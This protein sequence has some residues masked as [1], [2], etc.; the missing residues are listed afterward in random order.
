MHFGCKDGARAKREENCFF[1]FFN[2]FIQLHEP[3]IL[4]L[5]K[6]TADEAVCVSE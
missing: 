1:G 6:W 3:W 2:F 5:D 4:D